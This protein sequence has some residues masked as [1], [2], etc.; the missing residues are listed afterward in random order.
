M[1]DPPFVLDGKGRELTLQA[2]REVCEF[3][4]WKLLAA[5]VRSNHVHV[6]VGADVEPERVMNDFKIY[7]SRALNSVEGRG[8]KR[9]ARHGSKR[10]LWK[11]QDVRDAIRY[12]VDEQ[13]EAMAVFLGEIP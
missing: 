8:R 9:W 11:D 3:R 5:H 13:G 7:A 10:W 4:G 1:S 6:V 12:V 2:I